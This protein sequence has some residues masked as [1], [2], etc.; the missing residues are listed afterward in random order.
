MKNIVIRVGPERRTWWKKTLQTLLPE[1]RVVLWDEDQFDPKSV[2]YAVVWDPPI[3]LFDSLSNLK[4]VASVGAGVSH[5]LK[6]PNYPKEIPIIRT[7]GEDLRKRMAEYVVLHVL[8]VHRKLNDIQVANDNCEWRQYVEPLAHEINVGIMGLGNL[9]AFA[10]E[11]LTSL[12]YTV[13]GW[14]KS[15]KDIK[16][17]SVYVGNDQLSKFLTNLNILVCMLPQTHLT[18]NIL[19]TE[20]FKKLPN[21]AYLINVGR[22]EN[23]VDRDLIEAIDNGILSG[24]T[25]DVFRQEPLPKAHSFWTHPK[26]FI[27]CHTAS[28]IEPKTGGEIIANN[29]K[30]YDSGQKVPDVVDM[31]K[32]Y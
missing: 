10:A 1:F 2:E 21:D 16:D 7:I 20:V 9:G 28:A 30:L 17:V 25:L 6:D 27:T 5:I 32:G 26:I 8:K 18:E 12:G 29:I 24:A 31:K 14:A 23:L 4:C 11:S 3:G 19:N 13:S 15:S 22:G